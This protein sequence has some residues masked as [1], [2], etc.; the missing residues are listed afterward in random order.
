MTELEQ[1]GAHEKVSFSSRYTLESKLGAGGMGVV[2]KGYDNVLHKPVAV[3]VLLPN[4]QTDA[5][6]RFHQ[7]AKMTAR[8]SHINI[9]TV[10]DFGQNEAGDLYLVMDFL[11]GESL[12][13]RLKHNRGSLPLA[14]SISI[15]LQICAGLQHAHAQGILHRDI[16]P[17]NIML[18]KDERGLLQVKIVDFGLAKAT[19]AEQ[20]LTT[21]G[22]RVGSPLYMSPEQ[23]Q[24][25]SIDLRADIYSLGCLMYKTLTGKPPLVGETFLITI[26]MHINEIPRSINDV[27]PDLHFPNELANIVAKTLEKDPDDRFQSCTEL[28]EALLALDLSFLMIAPTAVPTVEEVPDPLLRKKKPKTVFGVSLNLA[29]AVIAL[30]ICLVVLGKAVISVLNAPPP[31]TVPIQTRDLVSDTLTIDLLT[32]KLYCQPDGSL[33][34]NQDFGDPDMDQIL[35]FKDGQKRMSLA[36]SMVTGKRFSLLRKMKKLE[37]LNLAD[38]KIDDEA[39]RPVGKVKSL[40]ALNLDSDRIGDIGF[41]YLTGLENLETLKCEKTLITNLGVEK[42]V[43]FPKLTSLDIS[44]CT[45]VTG[46]CMDILS[47]IPTLRALYVVQCPTIKKADIERFRTA[48]NKICAVISEGQLVTTKNEREEGKDDPRFEEEQKKLNE[49]RILERKARA[50]FLRYKNDMQ[51]PKFF[52]FFQNKDCWKPRKSYDDIKNP[53]IVEC[54]KDP[55]LRE[56]LKNPEAAKMWKDKDT[57][58]MM[59][60]MED[61]MKSYFP[62]EDFGD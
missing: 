3:K 38:T 23:A 46:E 4:S 42:L 12:H 10:L 26:D 28:S 2:Y 48:T 15:F 57:W 56:V 21:T 27:S 31:P 22:M 49:Q 24:T 34:A 11:D 9:L 18:V 19:G 37:E 43:S 14:E 36:E 60:T 35:R 39:L 54:L 41:G 6:I 45:G 1:T 59:Q 55:Q 33:S 44:G 16:K 30:V 7:E 25:E 5:I 52:R 47:R 51:N 53:R 50:V 29:S 20:S 58:V 62:P 61:K 32:D 8:L 17:S 40:K 13:D